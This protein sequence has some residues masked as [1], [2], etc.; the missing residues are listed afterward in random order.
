MA[1]LLLIFFSMNLLQAK[2]SFSD[3]PCAEIHDPHECF[4]EAERFFWG[5]GRNEDK[6]AAISLYMAA[7]EMGST[8][9]KARLGS[10]YLLGWGV[11]KNFATSV[12]YFENA[13]EKQE[14]FR[15]SSWEPVIL[16]ALGLIYQ[17]GKNE[18]KNEK[19]SFEYFLRA[20]KLRYGPAQIKVAAAYVKGIGTQ[21]DGLEAY[22][23]LRAAFDGGYTSEAIRKAIQEIENQMNGEV[24]ALAENLAKS[25]VE[26]Y[27]A[28]PIPDI[29][30]QPIELT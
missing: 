19:K 25:R 24:R 30:R 28:I 27:R 23:W 17:Q 29:W 21:P 10:F 2:P 13:L 5:I 22:A 18:Y 9:A 4:K 14:D 6:E 7:S 11:E 16:S 26:N 3:S 1:F 8:F 12:K 20:A 15:T